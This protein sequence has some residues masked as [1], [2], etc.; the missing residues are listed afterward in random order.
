[1]KTIITITANEIAVVE[2]LS[3]ELISKKLISEEQGRMLCNHEEIHEAHKGFEIRA[4]NKNG[5]DYVVEMNIPEWMLIETNEVIINHLDEVAAIAAAIEHSTLN[6]AV[7]IL[8]KGLKRDFQ[9]L[10]EQHNMPGEF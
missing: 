6:I 4:T 1:M 7:K 2:K 10:W 8:L 3:N 9:N 5:G